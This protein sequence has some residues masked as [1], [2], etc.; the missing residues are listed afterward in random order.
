MSP[1]SVLFV[2][3][4]NICRSPMAEGMFRDMVV[5]AGLKE[6]IAIDSAGTGDWHI[7][8]QPDR[9]AITTAAKR[10]IDITGLRARQVH[11]KDFVEFDHILVMDRSNLAAVQ[12]MAASGRTVP[13]LF[14]D[15]APV[16]GLDDVPDPYITG[17][18]DKV[19]DLI[20]AGSAGLLRALT[21]QAGGAQ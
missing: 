1:T 4:G 8:E 12:R 13:R 20:E 14:L 5:K 3:L 19:L 17:G 2:C 15:Y 10:G 9:R 18:F 6:V 7:G 16:V 11:E 21:D